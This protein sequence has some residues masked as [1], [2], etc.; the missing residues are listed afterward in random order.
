MTRPTA[1]LE[2]N[3]PPLRGICLI[4]KGKHPNHSGL[5]LPPATAAV[6]KFPRRPDSSTISESIPLF[7]IGRNRNGLWIA[8]EAEGRTGGLFLLK[9]SALRFGQ[10]NSGPSGCA[11]MLLADRLELDVENHGNPLV[12]WLAAALRRVAGLLPDHPPI[13]FRSGGDFSKEN[14]H[15]RSKTS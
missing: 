13:Q 6:A 12:A 15:D 10:K 7:F 3:Q 5:R 2:V 9:R 8:R 4:V 14:V 11:T 1:H